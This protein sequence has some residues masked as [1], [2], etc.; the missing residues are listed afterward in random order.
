MPDSHVTWENDM[1]IFKVN[2]ISFVIGFAGVTRFL[3]Y[4]T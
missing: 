4:N 1:A 2:E 3:H